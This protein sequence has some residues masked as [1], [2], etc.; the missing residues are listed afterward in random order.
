MA[1]PLRVLIIEDFEDDALLLTR[2]LKQGGYQLVHQRVDNA[3]DLQLALQ[4]NDWDLI[5]SDFNMPGF[6]GHEALK[7]VSSS[8]PDI[9]FIIV[10]GAIGEELAVSLV[11]AGAADYVMKHNLE[12]LPT[13][14]DRALREAHERKLYQEAQDQIIHSE[15]KFRSLF[16]GAGDAIF[17]YDLTGQILEVN[18]VA[19][20]CSGMERSELLAL[21]VRQLIPEGLA[22]AFPERI[23]SL[24]QQGALVYES[25]LVH[26]DG[27]EIPIEVNSRMMEYMGQ[28]AILSL[29]RDI[30]ERRLASANLSSA[31]LAAEEA[32]DKIDA[33]LR[34]VIDGL[35]VTDQSGRIVLINRKAEELLRVESHLVCGQKIDD[36]IT[37]TT[38]VK[39]VLSAL[40]GSH[41]RGPVEWESVVPGHKHL[42]IVQAGTTLVK[43]QDGYDTGAVS[44]LRDITQE[45]ELDRMK[46]EFVTVAA[47]ELGTPLATIMGF[48][49]LLINQKELPQKVRQESLQYIFEKTKTLEKIV[50]ELLNLSRI[51][52]GLQ[53]RLVKRA[54]IL[55]SSLD[56]LIGE[57]RKNH[58]R[59]NFQVSF[60]REPMNLVCDKERISQVMD[61]LINNAIKFSMKD[62]IVRIEMIDAD[63]RYRFS[64]QDQGVGMKPAQIEHVFEKFYRGE[65]ND[66][67]VG[68]LGLGL[69]IA[70]NIVMA[71]GGEIWI[72]SEVGRGTTV[73]FDLPKQLH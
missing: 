53:H 65:D 54:C 33:I 71:H 34:S 19:C 50:D 2:C 23:E 70:K 37:Q 11:K 26:K 41:K 17:F 39:D 6:N 51:E 69:C 67:A 48:A 10:S 64:V 27:L 35:I 66:S 29:L 58:P 1:I 72:H 63:D 8:H 15:K 28:P 12:R 44:V 47:H 16:D 56:K 73:S 38:L 32:R 21:N 14:V 31:M 49:E 30:S 43:N 61:N 18:H 36:A 4:Q 55:N 57:L 42:Q 5:L 9:P 60:P 59:R 24:R 20:E 13:A 3:A 62:Q 40:S 22:A 46:T 45:R 7:I 52:F 68:G 25:L